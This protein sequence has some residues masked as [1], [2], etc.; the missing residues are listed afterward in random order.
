VEL[1]VMSCSSKAILS[2]LRRPLP[3]PALAGKGQGQCWTHSGCGT[4][5]GA[6]ATGNASSARKVSGNF[7]YQPYWTGATIK[8]LNESPKILSGEAAWPQCAIGT[9]RKYLLLEANFEE[10]V[11]FFGSC[12]NRLPRIVVHRVFIFSNASVSICFLYMREQIRVTCTNKLQKVTSFFFCLFVCLF[13][14]LEES[15]PC[16]Y[17]LLALSFPVN[18]DILSADFMSMFI[19]VYLTC[20]HYCF[21]TCRSMKNQRKLK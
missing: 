19:S 6:A 16:L 10:A 20:L 8:N 17:T 3:N 1:K 9:R 21:W 13:V 7:L 12:E 4:P 14:L 2:P 18:K 5:R 15:S 11:L